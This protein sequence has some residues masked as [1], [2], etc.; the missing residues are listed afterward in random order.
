MTKLLYK[1]SGWLLA[2]ALLA[3]AAPARAAE[4]DPYLPNDAHWVLTINARQ[5]LESPL[6]KKLALEHIQKVLQESDQAK[7]TM[8]EL[9]FDPLKDIDR[10]TVAGPGSESTSTPKFLVICHGRFDT[11]KFRT[12]AEQEAKNENLRILTEDGY[13]IYEVA[14]PSWQGGE[15]RGSRTLYVAIVDDHTITAAFDK[16]QVIETLEKKAGKKSSAI[17]PELQAL[18]ARSNPEQSVSFVLLGSVIHKFA[19]EETKEHVEPIQNVVGGL[20]LGNEV[21]FDASIHSKD[22]EAAKDLQ[23]KIQQAVEQAKGAIEIYK[24]QAP[25]VGALLDV[26]DVLKVETKDQNVLLNADVGSDKIEKSLKKDETKPNH[27]K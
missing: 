14:P 26:L 22:A 12:T 7:K 5:L 6:V 27:D 25:A 21:K 2:A 17:P 4:T 8:Q 20:N 10:I 24:E 16:A 19:S 11:A 23:Q 13:T 18:L 3:T 15:A 1:Y 9:G